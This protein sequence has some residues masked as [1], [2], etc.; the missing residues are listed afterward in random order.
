[1]SLDKKMNP[2][3]STPYPASA[4]RLDFSD[5]ELDALY[6]QAYQLHTG[7]MRAKARDLFSFLAACRPQR[8][9]KALGIVLMS[10]ENYTAAIPV[11]TAAMLCDVNDDAA[12]PVACAEC[13]ALTGQHQQALQVFK[14]AKKMLLKKP[15]NPESIRLTAHTDGWLSILKGK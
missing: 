5:A 1:M 9:N 6:R 13:L 7:G 14:N 2:L 3:P 11:L 12:L 4:P 15:R 8:Y 10:E